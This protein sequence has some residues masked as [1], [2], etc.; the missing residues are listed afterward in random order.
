MRSGRSGVIGLAAVAA[1][2]L[3]TTPA[4]LG[5]GHETDAAGY[6][7]DSGGTVVRL[8]PALFAGTAHDLLKDSRQCND[9][10]DTPE[11]VDNDR[12]FVAA[13]LQAREKVA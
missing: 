10:S 4:A 2:A 6:C 8:T 12:N 9:S 1:L 11:L 3:A 13:G 7:E 5:D